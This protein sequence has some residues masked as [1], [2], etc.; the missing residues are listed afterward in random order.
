MCSKFCSGT[1][2]CVVWSN[3]IVFLALEI[4]TLNYSVTNVVYVY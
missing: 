1:L 4:I 2:F 3:G